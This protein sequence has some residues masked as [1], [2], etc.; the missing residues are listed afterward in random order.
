MHYTKPSF[1]LQAVCVLLACVMCWFGCKE[2]GGPQLEE[3]PAQYHEAGV[4]IEIGRIG[5]PRAA[6]DDSLLTGR[7]TCYRSD[8]LEDKLWRFWITLRSSIYGEDTVTFRI[9]GLPT[10]IFRLATVLVMM[11]TSFSTWVGA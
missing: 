3:I 4:P 6:L 2:I 7:A 8:S 5:G 11:R 10:N 9:S 1:R